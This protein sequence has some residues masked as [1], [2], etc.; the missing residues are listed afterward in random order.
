M[1]GGGAQVKACPLYPGVFQGQC[2]AAMKLEIVAA[3]DQL[4]PC[5]AEQMRKALLQTVL[6]VQT[7]AQQAFGQ[8]GVVDERHSICRGKVGKHLAQGACCDRNLLPGLG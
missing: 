2:C 6:P 1:L 5:T 4:Q 8:A 3:A 7:G